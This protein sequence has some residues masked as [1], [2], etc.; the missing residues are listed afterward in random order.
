MKSDIDARTCAG[1]YDV[2]EYSW[3]GGFGQGGSPIVASQMAR[4]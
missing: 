1:S 4:Y 3:R 2:P